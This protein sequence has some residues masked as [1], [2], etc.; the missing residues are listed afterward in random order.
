MDAA[1]LRSGPAARRWTPTRPAAAPRFARDGAGLGVRRAPNAGGRHPLAVAVLAWGAGWPATV[2]RSAPGGLSLAR[3]PTLGRASVA[4]VRRTRGAVG[5]GARS[6]AVPTGLAE[7]RPNT[8]PLALE[9][10]RGTMRP[11]PAGPLGGGAASTV[12][13]GGGPQGE[14]GERVRASGLLAETRVPAGAWPTA[15]ATAP[16]MGD[17]GASRG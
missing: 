5:G 11:P 1:R 6:M 13:S 16:R 14:R 17:R 12:A 2:P 9:A 10:R 7:V 4:T 3:Y 8:G 15:T